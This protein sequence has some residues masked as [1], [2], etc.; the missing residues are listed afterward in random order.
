MA[1]IVCLVPK[2]SMDIECLCF[3]EKT[4][5]IHINDGGNLVCRHGSNEGVVDGI[6]KV[7]CPLEIENERKKW[8][9]FLKEERS[10]TSAPKTRRK[11]R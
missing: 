3:D 1:E 10:G 11:L 2:L 5:D 6:A 4:C 9:E 7:I 8:E